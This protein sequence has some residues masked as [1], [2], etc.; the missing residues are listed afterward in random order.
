MIFMRFHAKYQFFSDNNKY[1]TYDRPTLIFP[2][3]KYALLI[4]LRL[5]TF[6][7]KALKHID[8]CLMSRKN[9]K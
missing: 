5:L 8:W 1:N 3:I 6:T 2:G 7:A 9:K 4:N